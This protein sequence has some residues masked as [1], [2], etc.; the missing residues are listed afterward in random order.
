VLAS[1]L[2]KLK[3]IKQA[4]TDA[5]DKHKVSFGEVVFDGTSHEIWATYGEAPDARF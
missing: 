2:A 5:E 1:T 3:E 4:A